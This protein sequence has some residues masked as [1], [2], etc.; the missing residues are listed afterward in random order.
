MTWRYVLGCISA[1]IPPMIAWVILLINCPAMYFPNSSISLQDEL[2][3]VWNSPLS[4]FY[5]KKYEAAGL[6]E[7]D[8]LDP[9]HFTSL[10]FLTRKELEETPPLKRLYAPESEIGFVAYTSGTTGSKLLDTYKYDPTL[11]VDVHRILVT[12]PPFNKNF[13]PMFAQMCRESPR[14]VFPISADYQNL[15]NSALVARETEPDALYATPTI[16]VLLAPHLNEYYSTKVIK[17][18]VLC[19]ETLTEARREEL[20]ALYPNAIIANTYGSSEIG[21]HLFFPCAKMLARKKSHFHTIHEDIAVTELID[22]ELV[23]TSFKNTVFPLIR[24]RTGDYFSELPPC[25]CGLPGPTLAWHGREN[26]DRLRINGIEILL[27]DVEKAFLPLVPLIGTQ[28]QLHFYPTKDTRAR[29]VIEIEKTGFASTGAFQDHIRPQII[30]TLKQLPISA[31]A[32]IA[33]AIEKELF[34][35]PVVELV[36]ALS[37]KTTKLKRFV[38]HLS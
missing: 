1:F 18:I 17:L 21:R 13:G 20:T 22:N 24:Y 34:T 32:T 14:P 30:A 33:D 29:I 2:S 8:I 6:S 28:Y 19:S 11:G 38:Q 36:E 15:A 35:E 12:Y 27:E 7:G 4:D 37:S 16:A 31:G 9:K 3:R 23:I 5:R 10:P 25:S 26:V